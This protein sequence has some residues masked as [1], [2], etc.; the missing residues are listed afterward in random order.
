MTKKLGS[1]KL[2]A[3][4]PSV[5]ATEKDLKKYYRQLDT[6]EVEEWAKGLKATYKP[7]PEHESIHRMRACM[8][9][10]YHYFPRQ[11]A[12]KKTSKYKAYSNDQLVQL[13]TENGVLYEASEDDRITR[14]RVIMA[15]RAAKVIE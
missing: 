15:L 1:G 2:V 7:C 13:A 12:A 4:H 10:L 5:W 14:M 3:G 9:V 6:V 11:T 8:A